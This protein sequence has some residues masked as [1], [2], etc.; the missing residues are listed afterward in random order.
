MATTKLPDLV[1]RLGPGLLA[2]DG[3]DTDLLARFLATRDEQAFTLLVRRH[4]PMV[5]GVCRRV[6]GD[7]HLAEDAFQA[8]Y[9]PRRP[10]RYGRGPL[11]RRGCTASRTAPH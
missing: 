5:F 9:S 8:V 6:T 3:S 10:A 1:S 11:C 4:G 2:P 7:H